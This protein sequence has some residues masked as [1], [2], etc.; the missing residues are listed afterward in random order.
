MSTHHSVDVPTACGD[1]D[2]AGYE[3]SG[4]TSLE[5]TPTI[6]LE[7][8]GGILLAEDTVVGQRN[9]PRQLSDHDDDDDNYQYNIPLF[10][11]S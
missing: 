8:S 5:T 9:G 11:N 3:T 2:L 7:T 10:V 6:L 4:L 1:A